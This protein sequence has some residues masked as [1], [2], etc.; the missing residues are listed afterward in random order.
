M[1]KKT[2]EV[3]PDIE[4]KSNNLFY[5]KKCVINNQRP[6]TSYENEH[7]NGSFKQTTRFINKVCDACR[8]AEEKKNIDWEAKERKLKELCDRH[9]RSDGAMMLLF[10]AVV[11]KTVVMLP[12]I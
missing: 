2:Y 8:W 10:Q 1:L 6:I 9:R 3:T 4:T 7:K 11:E 12:I 5:C